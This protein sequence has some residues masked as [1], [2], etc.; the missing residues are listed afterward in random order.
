MHACAL[1]V[2]TLLPMAMPSSVIVVVGAEG[3]PEYG[4]QFQLWA[5]RWRQP[6][7]RAGAEFVSIGL[8]DESGRDDRDVLREA[9]A[10]R[11]GESTEPLW[12][13]LIGHG[14]F[15][16]KTPRFNL[17]GPDVSAAE[18]A[19]WLKPV[20]RPLV[21]IKCAA[22]SGPFLAEL[23]GPNR[24]V[25]AATRS[26]FEHNFARF[27]DYMS[28]AIADPQADLDKDEQTSVL[29]AFLLA[30][31]RLKEFYDS[32][33]RLATEHALLDDTGDKLGTP[34]DWF[35][36]VRAVKSA[37]TG[38]TPDGALARRV[39][40]VKS[41]R[42][43]QLSPEIRARRDQLE[44]Q[45]SE[46]RNRKNQLPEPEYLQLIEPVLLELARLYEE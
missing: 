2:T 24:I 10:A 12:I 31:S 18:L 17:R 45:L 7:E 8:N 1:L 16:G 14:T 44:Q 11:A 46:L 25:I 22:S 20:A 28:S 15:D 41:A 26:G 3:T 27:G 40:L 34:A 21:V 42:E 23:S 9:I 43:E 5:S 38:A 35:Q 6:A 4:K 36:G 37:K 30:S 39:C 19:N 29:E 33:A 32:D 13:V